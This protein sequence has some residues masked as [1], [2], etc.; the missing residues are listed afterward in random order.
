MFYDVYSPGK[1]REM[2]EMCLT[3]KWIYMQSVLLVQF[4]RGGNL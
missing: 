2:L 4:V 3:E 1:E